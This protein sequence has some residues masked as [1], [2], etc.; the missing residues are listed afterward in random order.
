MADHRI[1]TTFRIDPDLLKKFRHELLDS[2]MK[3][4]PVIEK[5]IRQWLSGHKYER[6]QILLSSEPRILPPESDLRIEAKTQAV[7]SVKQQQTESASLGLTRLG[8]A[9]WAHELRF[10]WYAKG[11]PEA[12]LGTGGPR[13]DR[14]LDG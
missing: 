7:T 11:R 3:M 1:Q 14:D 4:T 2:D 8:N 6:E 12:D 10:G 5:L 13:L 9:A